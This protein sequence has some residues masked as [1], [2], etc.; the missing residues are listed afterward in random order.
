MRSLRRLRSDARRCLEEMTCV[1]NPALRERLAR[2][3]AKLSE[4]A[5]RIDSATSRLPGGPYRTVRNVL[6]DRR[7]DARP[8]S[9][10]DHPP[11][12]TGS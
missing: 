3:A 8:Y 6:A 11:A 2:R 7:K 9:S 10:A 5:N 1:R 12:R 4:V